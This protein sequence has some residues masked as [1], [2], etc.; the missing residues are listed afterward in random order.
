MRRPLL[1]N[2]SETTVVPKAM[3]EDQSNG[4]PRDE[5]NNCTVREEKCYVTGYYKPDKLRGN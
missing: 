4:H 3:A 5:S 2:R 1:G